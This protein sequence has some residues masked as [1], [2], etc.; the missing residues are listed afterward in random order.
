MH[1]LTDK[2]ELNMKRFK[3]INVG[4]LFYVVDDVT[5]K[6]TNLGPFDTPDAAQAK[7]DEW[8]ECVEFIGGD[9]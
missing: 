5:Y 8:N 7:A 9:K 4:T 6:S 1:P 2:P 3:V